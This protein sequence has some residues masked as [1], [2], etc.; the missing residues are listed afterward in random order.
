VRFA[1]RSWQEDDDETFEPLRRSGDG[2]RRRLWI[3]FIVSAAR[4]GRRGHR[5]V[6]GSHADAVSRHPSRPVL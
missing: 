2:L 1:V 5:A 4:R 3:G 6:R